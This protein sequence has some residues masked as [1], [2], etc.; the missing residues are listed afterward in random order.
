MGTRKVVAKF[1]PSSRLGKLLE[2][3]DQLD[4]IEYFVSNIGKEEGAVGRAT[5]GAILLIAGLFY[6]SS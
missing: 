2:S 5:S 6:V 1:D 4:A 3:H